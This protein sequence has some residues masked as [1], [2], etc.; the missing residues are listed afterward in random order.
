MDREAC[1]KKLTTSNQLDLL[2][3]SSRYLVQTRSS[4]QE[5]FACRLRVVN[6]SIVIGDLCD[7]YGKVPV[8]YAVVEPCIK[9]SSDPITPVISQMSTSLP[10]S[11][12]CLHPALFHVSR[13]Q[14][15]VR[16]R[17]CSPTA[18]KV[19]KLKFTSPSARSMYFSWT[20]LATSC[21][22]IIPSHS[23]NFRSTVR[24]TKKEQGSVRLLHSSQIEQVWCRCRAKEERETKV[25][26][27]KK[28]LP[29]LTSKNVSPVVLP[30]SRGPS[31]PPSSST[32]CS[33]L[34]CPTEGASDTQ[35]PHR[36]QHQHHYTASPFLSRSI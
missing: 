15:T 21:Q 8:N 20:T 22:C 32:I 6:E 27:K 14:A 30:L 12:I 10:T 35:D 3:R 11:Y 19:I 7:K 24:I 5:S 2:K 18:P 23:T 1:R 29:G 4:P 33:V 9:G 36:D 28:D 25:E 34:H 13:Y 16:M 17:Y 26:L 31:R